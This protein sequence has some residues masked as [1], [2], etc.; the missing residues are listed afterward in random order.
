MKCLEIGQHANNSIMWQYHLFGKICN[1][2][3]W[4]FHD[5]QIHEWR[6]C[7]M[8]D[9]IT[10]YCIVGKGSHTKMH[11]NV[12]QFQILG[13][14]KDKFFLVWFARH[15]NCRFHLIGRI[16]TKPWTKLLIWLESEVEPDLGITLPLEIEWNRKLVCGMSLLSSLEVS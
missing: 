6:I 14:L 1:S 2:L 11:T 13:W 10:I 4:W 5:T 7:N 12:G 15:P 3:M 8:E 16:R 9:L